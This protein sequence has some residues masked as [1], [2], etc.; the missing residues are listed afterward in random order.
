MTGRSARQRAQRVNTTR[1]RGSLFLV[2]GDVRGLRP[3][4]LGTE[5]KWHRDGWLATSARMLHGKY[6]LGVKVVK[7]KRR[8]KGYF[9]PAFRDQTDSDLARQA[10]STPQNSSM[11]LMSSQE[12]VRARTCPSRRDQN[13]LRRFLLTI[14]IT[15]E[16]GMP[17]PFLVLLPAPL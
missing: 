11:S 16:V 9:D 2:V 8:V 10:S 15:L 17:G 7:T 1:Y 14:Y 13:G 5:S 12:V 6:Q 3:W 4:L